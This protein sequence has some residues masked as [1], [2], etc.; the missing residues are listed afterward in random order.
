MKTRE[1][2][3][4]QTRD[5][6]TSVSAYHENVLAYRQMRYLKVAAGLCL[7][8]VVAYLWHEPLEGRANG[9]TWLGYTLGGLSFV[10]VLWLAWFGVRKRRYG[11]VRWMLEDWLSGHVYL[12]LSLIFISLLHAGFQFGWNV[13]TLAFALM[14]AV[15]ASGLYGLYAALRL[16]PMLSANRQGM[17][18]DEMLN[19][20]VDLGGEAERM[21]VD[22]DDEINTAVQAA[23]RQPAV[24][25]SLLGRLLG[26]PG[27]C[28]TTHARQLIEQTAATSSNRSEQTARLLTVL[29]RIEDLLAR[30]RRDAQ[31]Q[32]KLRI[33][34]FLH[35]PLTVALLPAL[36]AHVLA[37]FFYW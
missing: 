29:V 9:G 34:R 8:A 31:L 23:R 7:A 25:A 6:A 16:P 10:L 12:G 26:R 5:R 18:F 2:A 37:V 1:G 20:V 11:K 33:W 13:H 15:I 27:S 4:S 35:V 30:L 19:R 32:A 21:A 28:Q 22:M 36:A 14:A 3:V 17:S 24:A